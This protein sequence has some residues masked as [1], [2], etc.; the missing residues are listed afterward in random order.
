MIRGWLSRPAVI[1]YLGFAGAIC[2]G[3][4]A[5]LFGAPTFIREDVTVST[6]FQ[7][8]D[9]PLILALWAFGLTALCTAWWFGRHLTGPDG[10]SRR[11]I[12]VTAALWI[13]PMLFVQPLGSRDMYAYACQG[14]L[15]DAGFNPSQVGIAAQPCPW[16]NSVSPVWRTTP[17]PYGPIFIMLAGLAAAFGSQFVALAIFRTYA[18]LGL[19]ALAAVL[20]VLA[21][22]R[23]MEENRASW[24]VLCCPIIAVHIISGG[25]NDVLT[26][27]LLVAGL[28]VLA[29]PRLGGVGL[30]SRR[31]SSGDPGDR[32]ISGYLVSRDISGG[33]AGSGGTAAG[34]LLAAVAG[35]A[36]VGGAIMVKT[37]IAVVVPF[38]MLLVAGGLR[39]SRKGWA[40][41]LAYGGA[42]LA[43]VAAAMLALSYASGLGLG[44]LVALSGAGESRSWTSPPTA[45]GFVIDGTSRLFGY[46]L[47][48]VPAVRT[49]ALVLLP[50]VLLAIWVKSWR[51]DPLYGAGLACVAVMFL[52]PITQ[53]WYLLWPLALF[54]ASP[55][56]TRWLLGVV[57]AQMFLVLPD[58]DG[59]WKEVYL[60][61]S[62]LVTGLIVVV[63]V[64]A[65]RWLFRPVQAQVDESPARLS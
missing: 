5:A 41:F 58:G 49:I 56:R 7:R 18:V 20:P 47:Y 61:M 28:A 46:N 34:R 15:Y 44:W 54:A 22:R 50:I 53:P 29:G 6:T 57:V 33:L 40:R 65:V 55:M 31:D 1:R 35:G 62:F 48:V 11:W 52:A 39:M 14:S 63:A 42:V 8:P 45:V 59:A 2:C 64:L 17:T 32:G 9:G 51:G 10:V 13:V 26:V 23:G 27:A 43:G 19:I 16:L 3:V 4:D 24:V 25:H 38:A 30:L 60:V 36:L 12:L 37:T 21:R